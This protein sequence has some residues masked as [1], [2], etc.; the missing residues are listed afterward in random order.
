M[1]TKYGYLKILKKSF[2]FFM[3]FCLI[4]YKS[5][6][7]AFA[8]GCTSIYQC[9]R[10]CQAHHLTNRYQEIK[11]SFSLYNHSDHKKQYTGNRAQE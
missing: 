1:K 9:I 5:I 4:I 11:I 6:Q 10:C 3:F 2:K 8:Q 7:D